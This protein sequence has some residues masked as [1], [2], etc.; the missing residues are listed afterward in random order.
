MLLLIHKHQ[1]FNNYGTLAA[2]ILKLHN[3]ASEHNPRETYILPKLK[4]LFKGQ[5]HKLYMYV[6]Y[7]HMHINK[8]E[9]NDGKKSSILQNLHHGVMIF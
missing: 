5:C 8:P 9:L 3:L 6:K 4:V 1:Q 7:A 2:E